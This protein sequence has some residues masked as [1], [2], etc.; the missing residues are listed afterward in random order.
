MTLIRKWAFLVRVITFNGAVKVDIEWHLAR[1][2]ESIDFVARRELAKYGLS[3]HSNPDDYD[4]V[5]QAIVELLIKR[6]ES[7]SY[8]HKFTLW[9]YVQL[10]LK[11]VMSEALICLYTSRMVRTMVRT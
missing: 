8:D 9:T 6:H 10:A 11:G 5:R 3:Q 1:H 2:A 4:D 7:P